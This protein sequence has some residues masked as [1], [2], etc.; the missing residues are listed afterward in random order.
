[1]FFFQG[2]STLLLPDFLHSLGEILDYKTDAVYACVFCV[3]VCT[4]T[5]LIAMSIKDCK[6]K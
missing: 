4:H 2:L 6:I 5:K 1:M 3:G